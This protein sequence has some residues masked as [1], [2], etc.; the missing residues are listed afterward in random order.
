MFLDNWDF[1]SNSQELD[2]HQAHVLAVYLNIDDILRPLLAK[3]R[4]VFWKKQRYR[5]IT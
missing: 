5:H 4:L 3:T 2:V 1:G